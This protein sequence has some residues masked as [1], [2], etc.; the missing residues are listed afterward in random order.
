M[1]ITKNVVRIWAPDRFM[2]HDRIFDNVDFDNTKVITQ[3]ELD[4]IV[5]NNK[6]LGSNGLFEKSDNFHDRQRGQSDLRNSLESV[7]MAAIALSFLP[8]TDEPT[9]IHSYTIKHC[10]EGWTKEIDPSGN[11]LYISNGALIAAAIHVGLKL[12]KSRSRDCYFNISKVYLKILNN[13]KK[14][15]YSRNAS[16]SMEY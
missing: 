10:V 16:T 7:N 11:G 8:R 12:K 3:Q 4:D 15:T 13:Y 6:D 14:V 9:S 5:T 1:D 2:V